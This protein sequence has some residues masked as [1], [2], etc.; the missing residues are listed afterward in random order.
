MVW[1]CSGVSCLMA[2]RASASAPAC[3]TPAARDG[4][5][6]AVS[7]LLQLAG[8]AQD[9]LEDVGDRRG[10]EAE[11]LGVPPPGVEQRRLAA[12]V[13]DRDAEIGLGRRGAPR[14]ERAAGEQGQDVLIHLVDELARLAE[15]G[16]VG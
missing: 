10:V 16:G 8:E 5:S 3:I 6:V 2:M 1:I 15:I 4:T 13:A 7:A 12:R 11:A 14:E 9:R